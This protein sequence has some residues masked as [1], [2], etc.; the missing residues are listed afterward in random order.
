MPVL[1]LEYQGTDL[2][3]PREVAEKELGLHPGDR[4]E[5]RP[6][7]V[8]TPIER[9]PEEVAKIEQALEVFRQAFEPEHLADW[10]TT[11][12]ALWATMNYPWMNINRHA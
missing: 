5:I 11:R 7:I 12:K 8:L 2:V 3:I 4:L 6:K 10:E 9:S 1:E